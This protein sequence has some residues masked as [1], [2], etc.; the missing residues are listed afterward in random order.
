MKN[1]LV[2]GHCDYHYQH[3]DILYG[4]RP[5]RAGPAV[6]ATQASRWYG[7]NRQTSVFFVDRPAR[8]RGASDDQAGRAD[9]A[10]ARATRSRR[11]DRV[12]DPFA[13]S[14]STLIACEQLGRR[15]FAVELDPG[16]LRRDPQPLRRS[17]AM[18]G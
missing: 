10:D 13:G 16:L 12:L 18:A 1:A 11:G 2:L 15:C 8:E 14:G 7:D 9:R 17:T 5:G 4:Y 6:A 3:E